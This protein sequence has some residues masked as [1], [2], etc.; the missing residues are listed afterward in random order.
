MCHT[1]TQH[2][3]KCTHTL[4]HYKIAAAI[5][6]GVSNL[7][8]GILFINCSPSCNYVRIKRREEMRRGED[9]GRVFEY[10]QE[11]Q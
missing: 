4:T 9:G 11:Y 2:T 5:S 8:I 7:P 10:I 6:S 3:Q 1:H